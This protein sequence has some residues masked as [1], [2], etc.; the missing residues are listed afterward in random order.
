[1]NLPINFSH[2]D[3]YI[4]QHKIFENVGSIMKRC[5]ET[6]FRDDP[7][8]FLEEWG[9]DAAHFQDVYSI[10]DGGI[11]FAR[12][13]FRELDYIS[14]WVEIWDQNGSFRADYT[15]FFDED[16]NCIDD[17]IGPRRLPGFQ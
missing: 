14:A 4:A 7:K 8:G 9:V 13:F 2:L 6:W 16:L 3:R 1:M 11:S 5:I 10:R 17:R 15:A 12:D